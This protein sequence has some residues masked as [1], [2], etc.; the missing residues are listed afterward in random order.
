MAEEDFQ[1][2]AVEGQHIAPQYEGESFHCM[3]CGVLAQQH[4]E[5]LTTVTS[6]RTG[7]LLYS[8][9]S[10]CICRNC[11]GKSLWK[12]SDQRCVDPVMGG[13]PRPHVEMPD[14]VKADYEE[15]RQIVGISPR[16]A[17]ALLR[18]AVQKLCVD[19]GEKGKNIDEDIASLVKKGLPVEVQQALDSLRVIGNEAVHPGELDLRDDVETATALFDLLNFVVKDRIAEPKER[20][21]IFGLLPDKKRAAIAERDGRV[22]DPTET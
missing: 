11:Q 12:D 13:G 17:C 5:H 20:R 4:W 19:L 6:V 9:Y 2:Q 14:D 16:G 18:L 15:A 21:R 22:A 8:G 3:H 10:K 7:E 1:P